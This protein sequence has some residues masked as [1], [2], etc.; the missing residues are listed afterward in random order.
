M[1]LLSKKS[2]CKGVRQ[3]KLN[4]ILREEVTGTGFESEWQTRCHPTIICFSSW[5]KPGWLRCFFLSI[6]AVLLRNGFT[7]IHNGILNKDVL[8]VTFDES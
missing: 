4:M 2:V 8:L 1:H 7:G 3:P 5:L 6:G